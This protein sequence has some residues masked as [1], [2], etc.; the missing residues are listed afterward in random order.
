M[1][2]RK[3]LVA[4]AIIA[5]SGF[6]VAAYF[7]VQKPLVLQLADSLMDL[8]WTF[9]VISLL[10]WNALALGLFTVRRLVSDATQDAA[11][12]ALACGIGLGE[13]G[14]L[15]FVLAAIGVSDFF[16]L[17]ATQLLILG[18]SA[19]KGILLSVF[20]L[21]QNSIVQ[22][23]SSLSLLPRWMRWA[24]ILAVT[25]TFFRTLLPPADAF[26]A[27][28]YHLTVPDLWLR[29]G[30]LRLYNIPHDWFPGLVEGMY[31]LGL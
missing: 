23:Q 2:Y 25:L 6:V 31:F 14:L 13:L 19:W 9:L 3:L 30:G 20:S 10:V 8:A 27:L 11:L 18:W 5:W 15:G 28:L 12:L 26:D 21:A 4:L 17:L 24:V 22:I 16:L 29:D 1:D 7:V